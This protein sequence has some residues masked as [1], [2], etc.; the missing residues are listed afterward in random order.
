MHYPHSAGC[1]HLLDGRLRLVAALDNLDGH[2]R[3]S[4]MHGCWHT[5]QEDESHGQ[6][7]LIIYQGRQELLTKGI[8]LYGNP[9][10]KHWLDCGFLFS[11]V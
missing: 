2:L 7:Q 8:H 10:W 1:L 6:R 11:L 3:H 9:R 5:E 4:F